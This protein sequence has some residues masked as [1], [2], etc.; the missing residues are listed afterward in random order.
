MN[1]LM[2]TFSAEQISTELGATSK[3]HESPSRLPRK[4]PSS[5]NPFQSSKSKKL[6]SNMNQL[7]ENSNI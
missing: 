1:S 7:F 5:S 2:F 3:V 4:R 6:S